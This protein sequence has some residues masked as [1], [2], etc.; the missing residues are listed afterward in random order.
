MS[1]AKLSVINMHL[2]S[3]CVLHS[4]K[5]LLSTVFVVHVYFIVLRSSFLLFCSSCLFHS[6]KVQFSALYN[7]IFA[8]IYQYG[9]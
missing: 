3:E 2:F 5:V 7:V 4:I 6:I 8:N 1:E 9:T